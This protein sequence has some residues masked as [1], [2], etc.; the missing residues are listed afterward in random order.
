MSLQKSVKT[1]LETLQIQCKKSL[2]IGDFT[3]QRYFSLHHLISEHPSILALGY[4]H[5]I[6][7]LLKFY[8][9]LSTLT[10][11]PICKTVFRK[12]L[13]HFCKDQQ[14]SIL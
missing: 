4:N 10:L 7:I 3:Y 14:K 6:S 8:K 1:R 5:M 12:T 11:T 13:K 9:K 2:G